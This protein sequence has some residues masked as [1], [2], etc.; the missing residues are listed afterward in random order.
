MSRIASPQHLAAA[1]KFREVVACYMRNRDLITVGAYRPGSDPQLD[2]AVRLW[3][4][5]EAFLKQPTDL[6]VSFEES[7]AQLETLV[8]TDPADGRAR[9]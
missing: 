3:P 1:Q 4:R 5:I 9:G 2:R 7:I 6:P 8:N